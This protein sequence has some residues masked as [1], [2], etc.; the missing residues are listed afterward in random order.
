MYLLPYAACGLVSLFDKKDKTIIVVSHRLST[1]RRADRVIVLADGAIVEQ[2]AP[3]EL[4][5]KKGA[6][7]TLFESQL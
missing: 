5:A 7:Y 3:A 2:G 1:V 4:L 6:Y